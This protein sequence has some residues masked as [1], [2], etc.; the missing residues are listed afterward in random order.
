MRNRILA[1]LLMLL[2]PHIVFAS[3]DIT[4]EDW[5][6][7]GF[8]SPQIHS[9]RAEELCSDCK[10]ADYA[11]DMDVVLLRKSGWTEEEFL[12][13]LRETAK[14]YSQCS[15]RIDRVELALADPPQGRTEWGKYKDEGGATVADLRRAVPVQG[16]LAVF[17]LGTFSD[18]T[19]STGFSSADWRNSKDTRPPLFNTVFLSTASFIEEYR[20]ER[21]SNPYN[22]LAH[23]MLHVLTRQG[24]H[25]NLPELNLLNIWKTRTN[26]ILPQHCAWVQESPLLR[27]LR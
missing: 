15:V 10:D 5:T 2:A 24:S 25:F 22:L 9:L 4:A 26:M 19:E 18:N 14:I 1:C 8:G 3:A 16:R 13:M 7:S 27:K 20:Q 21:V 12:P 23:E 11:L 17:L 6:R